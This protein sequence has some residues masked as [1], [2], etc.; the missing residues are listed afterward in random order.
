MQRALITSDFPGE[1]ISV[2]RHTKEKMQERM[3]VLSTI[4]ERTG[5][6]T[7]FRR[8]IAGRSSLILALHRVLPAEE[9][10][11]CYN[12]HLVL[13]ESAFVSLLQLL[14]RDY[15]V[16]P[17]EELLSDPGGAEGHPK[18]AI[19]FDDGWEDN[20]RVAFPHLLRFGMPATI[21]ACTGLIDTLQLLPEER[22]ARLWSQCSAH[23]TLEELVV[24]L[25][26]WGMGKNKNLQLRPRQQYWSQELKRMPMNA[27]LLLL[28][29]LEQRYQ[30][31]I[32]QSRRFLTWE[33]VCIMT[34]TGLIRI[35]SHTHRHA[36]LSS[37]S[38]RD[39]RQE[40]DDARITLW[41]HVGAV[42]DVLA[43]PNGMYNRRVQE[44]V[45]S[46]GFTTALSTI[47]GFF[48]RESNPLAIPR[49][50]VDNTTVTD[51]GVQLSTSRAS[52]YFL[53]SGLRS[54]ASF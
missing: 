25:N 34:R 50:A 31:T 27:R 53:S 11:L 14:Q 29:H 13:S 15:Q 51:T 43:Y 23:S 26:H 32:P 8:A 1:L 6:A 49:I 46:M 18:V 9:Q 35:G 36:T 38:D 20:Y 40:L 52:F 19:T 3:K 10:S 54:A 41:K 17:L 47:P 4:V 42:A 39:I 24:D 33:Q 45:R 22:F 5:I 7:V 16:V 12:P 48:T 30:M 37:E 44:L 2:G 21:F 28:D